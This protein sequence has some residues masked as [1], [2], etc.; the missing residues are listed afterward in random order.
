[1]QADP[2]LEGIFEEM[3]PV[4]V[5]RTSALRQHILDRLQHLSLVLDH[6]CHPM[7]RALRWATHRKRQSM[8]AHL[9]NTIT[10]KDRNAVVGYGDAEFK[11][12]SPTAC[13]RCRLRSLCLG[14]DVEK[15]RTSK[16]CC[17]CHQPMTGMPSAASGK[18]CHSLLFSASL[19]M[20]TAKFAFDLRQADM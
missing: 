18:L 7:H 20:R 11:N 13:L 19:H 5:A 16:L 1:M 6:F 9:C 3:P 10:D 8:M 2:K 17:A 4:K 15:F 14:Y 12:N